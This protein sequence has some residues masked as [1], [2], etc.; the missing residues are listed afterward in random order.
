MLD[1]EDKGF[2]ATAFSDVK[3]ETVHAHNEW[4]VRK[5]QQKNQKKGTKWKFWNGKIQYM[6]FLK[7]T[8][9]E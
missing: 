8:R 3:K 4:I 1:F 5:S 7:S 6:N 9:C 2:K